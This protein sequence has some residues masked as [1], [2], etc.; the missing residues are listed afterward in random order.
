MTAP[1]GFTWIKKPLLAALARPSSK[2]EFAWLRDH[3]VQVL[4]TLT[5]EPPR[6][7][8]VND[9]GLMAVHDPI[10]DFEAPSQEQLDRIIGVI[11]RAHEQKM[12]VAVHCAAGLGRTGTV[13]AAYLVAHG[14]SARSAIARMRKLR[15]GSIETKEQEEAIRLYARTHKGTESGEEAPGDE[16][17]SEL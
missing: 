8:W 14:M 9:A 11:D 1:R 4:L 13:L 7:D 6:R 12:G 2:E 3:G 17:E 5:E 15:P 10:E 16:P